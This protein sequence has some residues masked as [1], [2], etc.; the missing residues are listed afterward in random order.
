MIEAKLSRRRRVR[1]AQRIQA[2]RG[3][4]AF[5]LAGA[6]R[7][8]FQGQARRVA[9]R[10][11]EGATAAELLPR[12]E[13]ERLRRLVTAIMRAAIEEGAELSETLMAQARKQRDPALEAL[14][15]ASGTRI[16]AINEATRARVAALLLEADAQGLNLFQIVNGSEEFVGLRGSVVE[17]YANRARAIGRTEMA[18]ANQRAAHLRYLAAGV[19][20]VD[21]IDGA[22]CGWTSHDDP[23]L[24]NG[25]RRTVQ[26]ADAFPTAHPNCT[27]VSLPVVVVGGREIE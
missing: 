13:D 17:T 24:A 18:I 22:D 2:L 25:S 21:I 11:R 14:L 4:W 16:V 10:M 6:L 3:R 1:M 27:R 7:G 23:D 5:R 20:E 12:S 8:F 26:E 19:T 15:R 9:G